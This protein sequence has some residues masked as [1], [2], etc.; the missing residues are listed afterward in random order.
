MALSQKLQVRQTQSL[1]MTPQLVQSI[2]L[3]RMNNT[4]LLKFVEEEVEKNPLLS[5]AEGDSDDRRGNDTQQGDANDRHTDSIKSVGQ[6]GASVSLELDT[7]RD[8]L[9]AKTGTSFENEFEG[10]TRVQENPLRDFASGPSLG[11]DFSISAGDAADLEAFIAGDLTL[12]DH[13]Q[14]QLAFCRMVQEVRH[15][16]EE[17]I[18]HLD[19]DGY[20]RYEIAE[21]AAARGLEKRACIDALETVQ[22]L[23]PVG[24]GARDLAECL[25]LQLREVNRLDPAMQCLLSN[26]EWLAKKDFARLSKLCQVSM[27]DLLD[28]V[29]EIRNLDPRPAR[30]FD[31][32]PVQNIAPDILVSERPDGSYAIE[33]NSDTLPRVLVDRTYKSV[34]TSGS[35]GDPAKT[36]F[37]DCF[38]N[39]TWLV[40]SLE[41]RAHTILKVM[42]EIVRQQ[43]DF[44]QHGPS[45]LKPLS[46]RQ[47]AEATGMHESTVSRVTSNKYVLTKRGL[48]ELKYFFTAAIAATDG[49]DAHSSEAV[50]QRI[51]KLI[52][53][54]DPKRVLSDDSIVS[55]LQE[56]GIDIARRTVAKYRES[57]NIASSVQR[58]REKKAMMSRA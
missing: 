58:R 14:Q 46:L 17:I 45:R 26:L 31:H 10:E 5:L 57:M 18:D 33:L 21:F 23:E 38:Q 15:A 2:K 50:R 55:A 35:T 29:Q 32:T 34:V 52:A 9:E 56:E 6:D 37:T 43:D 30:A 48:Y 25:S 40:R 41:Q 42:T 51:R 1:T 39:A 53:E 22:G 16:A 4:D 44:F 19:E 24:I 47:V 11:T 28:M 3:L 54:E 49:E 7:S 36:F 8:A 12:K 27:D 13:L 20:F